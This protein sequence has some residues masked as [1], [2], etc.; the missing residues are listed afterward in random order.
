MWLLGKGDNVIGGAIV[1][2]AIEIFFPQ[3]CLFFFYKKKLEHD[4]Y[5]SFTTETWQ[6]HS[7]DPTCEELSLCQFAIVLVWDVSERCVSISFTRRPSHLNIYYR[8]YA[9]NTTLTSGHKLQNT[10]EEV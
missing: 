7:D 6:H 1:R 4:F 9:T 2:I 5:I 8:Q 3:L 10:K